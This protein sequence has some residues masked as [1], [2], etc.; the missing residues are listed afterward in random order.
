[1]A[2]SKRTNY[3]IDKPFQIGFIVKYLLTILLTVV[4][5]FLFAAG[6]LYYKSLFGDNIFNQIVTIKKRSNTTI[7]GHKKFA[8]DA[9]SMIIYK[10]GREY[11]VYDP[12]GRAE[13]GLKKDDLVVVDDEKSLKEFYGPEEIRT[14]LFRV[15]VPPLLVV[16]SIIMII[17]CIYSLFFSHR[18]AGPI[19]RLR[20]SLDRMIAGDFDFKIR[21]RKGDFFLNIVEKLELL[22]LKIKNNE[23]SGSHVERDKILALKNLVENNGSKSDILKKI[24]E[25]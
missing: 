17:I 8:Y 20:I 23:F 15:I 18:M 6:W 7:E 14:N 21:A 13:E 3:L 22:R 24:G 10:K 5:I 2:K 11:F 1:V 12:K 25:L 16:C 19:Y 9:E 4:A